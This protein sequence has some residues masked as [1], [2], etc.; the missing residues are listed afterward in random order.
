MRDIVIYSLLALVV[1]GWVAVMVWDAREQRK[2]KADGEK[3][4]D[5]E[6]WV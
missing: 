2:M 1:L 6:T 4:T 3:E 5:M